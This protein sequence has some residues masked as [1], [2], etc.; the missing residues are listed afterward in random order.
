M[1][2]RRL[3][4]GLGEGFGQGLQLGGG[5]GLVESLALGLAAVGLEGEL[6]ALAAGGG[7]PLRGLVDR[8][9][10]LAHLFQGGL[11]VVLARCGRGLAE[12]WG[13]REEVG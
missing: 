7:G 4:S 9:G 5:A 13:E 2:H 10:S 8:D 12:R 6:R 3:H 1:A 11:L